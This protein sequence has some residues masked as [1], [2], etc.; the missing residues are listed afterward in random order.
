MNFKMNERRNIALN[1]HQDAIIVVT[2]LIVSV[3]NSNDTTL[4]LS[5]LAQDTVLPYMVVAA[6]DGH[7]G[8]ITHIETNCIHYV[9]VRVKST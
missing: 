7:P 9:C 6:M 5:A 4:A 3:I 1:S 8:K 2:R